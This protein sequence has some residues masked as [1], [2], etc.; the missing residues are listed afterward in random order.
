MSWNLSYTLID[1]VSSVLMIVSI[2]KL[3]PTFPALSS[4]VSKEDNLR[5]LYL[6]SF[7]NSD[8]KGVGC[9]LLPDVL[10]LSKSHLV[11]NPEAVCPQLNESGVGNTYSPC[12]LV[13]V[14]QFAV[15]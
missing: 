7:I 1:F 4:S 13:R 3:K 11:C 14:Q 10:G 8:I 6:I 15:S 12:Y 2:F 9:T 5:T